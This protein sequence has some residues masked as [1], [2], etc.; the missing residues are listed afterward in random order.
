MRKI[1]FILFL[2]TSPFL[3]KAQTFWAENFSSPSW[4]MNVVQGI[5]GTDP[6]FF[7][8]SAAE[9]GGIPPN[10][11]A[12]ASCG[13]A[14]NS[15]NTLHVTSVFAPTNGASY[16]AGGFCGIFTCPQTNR[17]AESPSINCSGYSNIT[18]LYNYIENGQGISDNATCWYFDGINWSQVDDMPKT[19]TGCGGQGLWTS[20]SITLPSSANNNA[21]VK[22]AFNWENND[23]GVGTDPSFAVD[24][25]SLSSTISAGSI[26][27]SNLVNTNLCA[28][29]TIT[30]PFTSTGAFTAGNVYTAQLS[31]PTGS[32]IFPVTIGTLISI[33][34]SGTISATIPCATTSGSAYRIRVIASTPSLMGTN[35]GSNI[36][37][38]STAPTVVNATMNPIGQVCQGTLISFNSTVSNGGANP[39]Y[40]WKLNN[41][42]VSNTNI[43]SSSALQNGD[44][45]KIKVIG[46]S[47]CASSSIDSMTFVINNILNN[48]SIVANAN[49]SNIICTGDAITLF[50]SGGISYTWSGGVSNNVSFM[51]ASNATY[52]VTGTSAN[53]CSNTSS[54]TVS[55]NN[56]NANAV[57]ITSNPSIVLVGQNATYTALIPSSMSSYSIKWYKQ[58][59]LITTNTN[60]NTTF[61]TLINSYNDSVYAKL[62]PSAGC[63]DKDSAKSNTIKPKNNASLQELNSLH[64]ISVSPNPATNRIEIK[65]TNSQN[66]VLFIY[67]AVGKMIVQMELSDSKTEIDVSHFAKGIYFLKMKA[68]YQKFL[69]E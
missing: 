8:T 62:L 20:R 36:T 24:D 49:P 21:N 22:I 54:I 38:G 59:V 2:C 11:G 33:S 50:G 43:Y 28:C 35:N 3:G 55:I 17:R 42:I 32:F 69:V 12:P 47:S 23:D 6:N 19:L 31:D 13:V 66:E 61:T 58:N 46:N 68:G 14:N 26:T 15:N 64:G 48:P 37:I 57:S 27:T 1:Y 51:P 65:R 53:G 60:P 40:E 10:L 4:T 41:T 18:L 29:Q 45:V 5:E 56:N 9:G 67:D 63:F 25:I 7:V 39:I 16:D 44:V 34:N 30:I 52:T